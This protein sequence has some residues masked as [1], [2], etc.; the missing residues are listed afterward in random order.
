[1]TEA[2]EADKTSASIPSTAA[3]DLSE[4]IKQ[5]M[6]RQPNEQV[7]CVH[8]FGDRYRCNWWSRKTSDDWRTFGTGSISK[9]M[10]LRATR[11]SDGLVIEDLTQ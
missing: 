3:A 5:T 2:Q 8:L 1:M 10:F 11:T 4:A 6:D 7:D 9:S